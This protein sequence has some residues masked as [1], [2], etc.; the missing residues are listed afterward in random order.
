M[1]ETMETERHET[2]MRCAGGLDDGARRGFAGDQDQDEESGSSGR[3]H[4]EHHPASASLFFCR[5]PTNNFAFLSKSERFPN[6]YDVTWCVGGQGEKPSF[7]FRS[8]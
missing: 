6:H 2:G 8:G 7:E 4:G 5:R 1:H 3:V